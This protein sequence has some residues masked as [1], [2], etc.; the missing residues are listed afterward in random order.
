MKY[1]FLSIV[2]LS[3]LFTACQ[4]SPYP[5]LED[6]IYA[7]MNTNYGTMVLK[8]YHDKT[9]L[10]VANFISLAEGT[11]PKVEEQ[12]Q[13]K[14][15]FDGLSFHR[16]IKGFMIQGGDPTGTGGGSPGYRFA[17][18]IVEGLT[19]DRK[20]ILS[21][22]N[23]GPATNGSQFFITSV[24]TPHLDGR[25]TV[26][27][28]LVIG[29]DV[30]D[31]IES[32]ETADADRPVNPVT[33]ESLNIIRNGNQAKSFNAVEV[34]ESELKAAEKKAA[35]EAARKQ[36]EAQ[37]AAERAQKIEEENLKVRDEATAAAKKRFETLKKKATT[38]DSGLK[39]H[40]TN[41]SNNPKPQAGSMVQMHYSGYLVDG[42]LFD[43]SSLDVARAMGG[44]N[45]QKLEMGA[46]GQPLAAPYDN[47]AGVIP[48]FKE[49]ML[50]MVPGDEAV[51]FIP[52]ALGYG[53]RGA[54]NVIPPNADLIFEIQMVEETN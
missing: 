27:G 42:T 13:G 12:Y 31:Q 2:F 11:N 8:L 1:L 7:E 15:Y 53:E 40:F 17:D 38:T 50:L 24:P 36:Q 49:A 10:T 41:K 44:V 25:H 5:D 46:Y 3:S 33:I 52:S 54:G 20:G 37:E 9:P 30:F 48:G 34:F 16:I 4:Q 23:A 19:H 22:A 26:F 43:S 47:T 28:E 39:I 51:V 32:V 35:E 18:E 6:G 45:A 29:E 21:M 14:K